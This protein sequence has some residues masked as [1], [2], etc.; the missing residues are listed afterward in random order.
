MF[1]RKP[2]PEG[3]QGLKRQEGFYYEKSARVHR[4]QIRRNNTSPQ[5]KLD[6]VRLDCV[7]GTHRAGSHP[8]GFGIADE[9]PRAQI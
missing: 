5:R 9:L 3:R 4:E 8:V 2:L 6:C 1:V 7:G